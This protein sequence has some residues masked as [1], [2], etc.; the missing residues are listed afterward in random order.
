MVRVFS[1]RPGKV[2]LRVPRETGGRVELGSGYGTRVVLMERDLWVCPLRLSRV[3]HLQFHP[4]LESLDL[5]FGVEVGEMSFL[6]I[7]KFST[8]RDGF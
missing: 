5:F 6:W 1:E 8:G 3:E 4:F 7:A 2:S